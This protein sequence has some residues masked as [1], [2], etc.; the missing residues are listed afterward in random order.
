MTET[1]LKNKVIKALRKDWPAIWF[2]KAADKFTSGIPDLILCVGGRFV[3]IELKTLTGRKRPLQEY[4]IKC[5]NAAGGAGCVCRSVEEV[6]NFIKEVS[7]NG[8][9]DRT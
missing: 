7:R 5:I 8:T 4:T 6:I 9:V 2:Y 3:A 1:Q